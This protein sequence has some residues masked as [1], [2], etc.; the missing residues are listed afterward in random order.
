MK[1]ILTSLFFAGAILV[2]NA[3]EKP[4]KVEFV[5]YDLPNGL[6]VILHKNNTNPLIAVS[7]L[8]H[9]GSKDEDT[10]RTG[11]AHFFEHLLFEGS[12]NIGRG[13][14]SELVEDAGGSLN[15]NTS[16]DRTFYFELL[17]SNELELGLW[18]ESERMLHAKVDQ[19]GVE[20]QRE[21]VKEEKR[22]RIDNQPYGTFLT[23]AF[24]LAFNEHPYRWMPIGSMD[25]LNAATEED[26]VKFYRTFYVPNNATLSIAGDIDIEETKKLVKK[27]FSGIPTGEKLNVFRDVE[28]LSP[29]N[30]VAKYFPSAPDAKKEKI[31]KDLGSKTTEEI[32]KMYFSN[33]SSKIIP[34]PRPTQVE[35]ALGG[36]KRMIVEDNVQLPAVLLG[37]R[38]PA[39]NSDD[40]YAVQILNRILSG[41][42]SARFNKTLVEKEQKALFVQGFP[43]PLE[44]PGLALVLGISNMEVSAEDLEKSMDEQID[45]LIAE[46][47]TEEEMEIVKNKIETDF[48]STNSRVGGI[49]ESLANFHVYFGSADQI[50]KQMEKYLSVTKEDIMRVAKKYYVKDNRIVLHYVPKSEQ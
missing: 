8:Y 27:Y 40:F 6:H 29:E 25:H 48:Y 10:N 21:V 17:P 22:Q 45:K 44:H 7:V 13:E 15:A 31:L 33:V 37:Y 3:Q 30:F 49:S 19:Q 39:Q 50:N 42:K 36:E 20:T 9:V 46:G 38:M 34:I 35:P 18:L 16:Q 12:T 47:V 43:L 11:F 5:E 32:L 28:F 4:K 2:S 14:Y 24:K 26:Y 41:S 1:R 23:N